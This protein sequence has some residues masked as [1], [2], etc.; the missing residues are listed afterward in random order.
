MKTIETLALSCIS[1]LLSGEDYDRAI[2]MKDAIN[3]TH[4]K[5]VH[6]YK[7]GRFLEC[8]KVCLGEHTE[9][10]FPMM[11]LLG[12]HVIH[13]S[14]HESDYGGVCRGIFYLYDGKVIHYED[15]SDYSNGGGYLW[16]DWTESDFFKPTIGM[17]YTSLCNHFDNW[18]VD[19]KDEFRRP[20]VL[21]S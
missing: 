21:Y 12:F 5:G 15:R 13:A 8:I 10:I 18:Y 4:H 1:H 14:N 2:S 16:D 17:D 19:F 11:G 6:L 3:N 7:A 20:V 9:N